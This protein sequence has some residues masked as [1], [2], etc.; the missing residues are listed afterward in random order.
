MKSAPP[1]GGS[2]ALAP[3][4][5]RP[6]PLQPNFKM[7][8]LP[9]P[10][11]HRPTLQQRDNELHEFCGIESGTVCDKWLSDWKRRGAPDRSAALQNAREDA[12]QKLE[13][14][15][16][17]RTVVDSWAMPQMIRTYGEANS[18]L[19]RNMI[20]DETTAKVPPPA[21]HPPPPR[22]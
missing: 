19:L 5:D 18:E 14:H 8:A 1:G 22:A 9:A 12:L 7:R 2:R 6:E 11:T 20:A 17:G 21:L 3:M 13:A 4:A 15:R 10:K 16:Q